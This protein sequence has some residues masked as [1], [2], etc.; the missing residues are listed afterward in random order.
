MIAHDTAA[1]AR[2]RATTTRRT[3][4][5]S[6]LAALA[7]VLCL[8]LATPVIAGAPVDINRADAQTL[9]VSLDGIGLAKAKAKAIVDY[10]QAHGPFRSADQLT[11]VKG[12]GA[13]TVERNR[14]NILLNGARPA[15]VAIKPA[16]KPA[17][18]AAA[19]GRK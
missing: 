17:G 10:R 13:R 5:R 6:M 16:A 4:M 3:V 8:A 7:L 2:L 9:A 12:I 14:A 19:A 18:K 11:E 15:A 1:S